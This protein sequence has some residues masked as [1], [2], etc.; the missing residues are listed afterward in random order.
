LLPFALVSALAAGA[1]AAAQSAPV[2]APV[3]RAAERI[4][5][6]NAVLVMVDYLTGFR[7]AVRTVD[8]NQMENNAEALAQTAAAFHIPVIVI[9][10]EG[11][12]RGKFMPFIARDLAGAPR[13]TRRQ[14]S[15][16]AEP[17]F[18]EAIRRTGR[19]KI[20][21]AGIS[22]DNCVLFTAIDAIRDGYDVRVV[23]DASPAES[24]MIDQ[25]ARARLVTAGATLHTWLSLGSE[26]VTRW[27]T[28]EGQ[29]FHQIYAAHSI[30]P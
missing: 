26:L 4:T 15:A 2:N 1:P 24:D 13:V 25:V 20:I 10:D 29:R 3:T 21:L 16:W 22:I 6:D 17:A 30:Y 14:P 7:P 28:P 8:P 11:P 27:D 12:N 19:T 23:V 18:R 9:G 5:P